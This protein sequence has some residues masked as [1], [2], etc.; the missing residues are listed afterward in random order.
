MKKMNNTNPETAEMTVS[1]KDN[2]SVIDE[3]LDDDLCEDAIQQDEDPRVR[4]ILDTYFSDLGKYEP[5]TPEKEKEVFKRYKAGETHLRDDIIMHNL[6]LVIHVAKRYTRVAK[7]LSLEDLIM[8][9][10]IGLM[11]AIDRFDISLDNKFSTYATWWIRQSIIRAIMNTDSS[12]RVPCHMMEKYLNAEKAIRNEETELDR[13]L[14]GEEIEKILK[15][16]S[17]SKGMYIQ[18]LGV[19][20]TKNVVSL[21][22][23]IVNEDGDNDTTILDLLNPK[24][25]D[26][27]VEDEVV[28]D[29][30]KEYI[31]NYVEERLSEKELE[32]LKRRF[33]YYGKCETLDMIGKDYHVTRERVRQIEGRA[34]LKLRGRT[35]ESRKRL[36]KILGYV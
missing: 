36:K 9:G 20:N 21:D 34:L 11:T 32:I 24:D 1:D 5:Y 14:S 12:I 35:P 8:E 6:R 19:Y 27:S 18:M 16:Y 23:P 22:K 10:N 15:E 13:H 7:S 29:I 4:S 17:S 2:L 28:R 25:S 3:E 33:G 26:I 30:N 31:W